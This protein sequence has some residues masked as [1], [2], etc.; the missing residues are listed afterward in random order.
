MEMMGMVVLVVVVVE[1]V[2]VLLLLLFLL[3][4]PTSQSAFHINVH[5]MVMVVDS[6]WD[7]LCL[8]VSCLCALHRTYCQVMT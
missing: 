7:C 2:V 1:E 4:E 8:V 3:I 6:R 5:S